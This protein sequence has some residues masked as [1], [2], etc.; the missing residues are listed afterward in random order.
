MRSSFKVALVLLAVTALA[1][2][3]VKHI[4]ARKTSSLKSTS[5]GKTVSNLK[6]TDCD[7]TGTKYFQ[8]QTL[9]LKGDFTLG[10]TAEFDGTGIVNQAF[11]HT[12]TDVKATVGFIT[13]Y[14]QNEPVNPPTSYTPGPMSI[15][16]SIVITVDAPSGNYVVQNRFRN[17]NNAIIQCV[18][19]T[20]KL[21]S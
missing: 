1:F 16:N 15:S 19:F 18:Q 10:S 11:T 12:S 21:S 2:F 8:I 4:S 17:E 13:I 9:T 3:G 6:W 7:G 20:F 14:N 5:V